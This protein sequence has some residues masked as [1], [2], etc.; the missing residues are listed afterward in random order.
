M[1]R[2]IYQKIR[3]NTFAWN[4]SILFAGTMA[5]NV[6][7]YIFHL[8][9]GRMTDAAVYGE[10]ESL[11]SLSHIISIPAATLGMIVTKYSAHTKA[12]NNPYGSRIIFRAFNQKIMTLGIPLFLLALTITPLVRD[13]LKIDEN[14]PIILLWILM[15]LGFFSSVTN[16]ILTG[17][18]KFKVTSWAGI[19]STSAKIIIG[20]GLLKIGFGVSGVLGGFILSGLIGY[21]IAVRALKFTRIKN[22]NSD[23]EIDWV[24]MKKYLL[25]ALMGIVAMTILGNV[26]MVLA[27]NKL[28]AITSGQYGALTVASKTIFFATSILGSVL[29]TM[30]A[31]E[32][33]KKGNSRTQLK[34]AAW[35]TLLATVVATFIFFVFPEFVLRVFFGDK[36]LGVAGYLGW[37]ALMV[38]LF[39][40]VNLII[41]YLLSI[42]KNKS[43]VYFLAIAAIEVLVIFF[44][45]K[46]IYDIISIVIMIQ[47]LAILAGIYFI[48]EG[49]KT[50]KNA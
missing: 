2:R 29:F 4:S 16:G 41:Q 48:F 36:Y 28:D 34:N 37:F 21:A 39:S 32:N 22:E 47:V 27:K 45:A 50:Q 12:E 49:N 5:A 14:W 31:E 7:N 25:P 20:V 11:I 17:W 1:V 33:H 30:S 9:L 23:A 42:H 3:G 15:L 46:T 10:I 26:D 13:F 40:F 43:A 6:L 24:A 35:L 18:Q 38:S 8:V 44:F 19:V